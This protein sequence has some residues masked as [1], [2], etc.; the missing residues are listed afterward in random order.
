MRITHI[1][2]SIIVILL[3]TFSIQSQAQDLT[4]NF[5][6]L[7]TSKK[8]VYYSM[9]NVN[10]SVYNVKDKSIKR[11]KLKTAKLVSD[12]IDNYPTNWITDYISLRIFATCNGERMNAESQNEFLNKSQIEILSNADIGS[13]ILID[14]KYKFKNSVTGILENKTI[15]F[16][17]AIL[18]EIE[19]EYIGGYE[20]MIKSLKENSKNKI[21]TSTFKDPPFASVRFTI[22]KSGEAVNPC[23]STSSGDAITDELLLKLINQMPKWKPASNSNGDAVDQEFIFSIGLVC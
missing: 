23:I 15:P 6:D 19:A 16:S 2:K 21:P 17:I 5:I 22:N 4:Y 3:S 8:I 11:K 7:Q 13:L 1:N 18:P 12:I 14:V 20:Q 10:F 9:D